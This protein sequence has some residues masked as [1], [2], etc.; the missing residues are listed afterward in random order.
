MLQKQRVFARHQSSRVQ[1]RTRS[2]PLPLHTQLSLRLVHHRIY[3]FYLEQCAR[4]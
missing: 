3:V 2:A 4:V 1:A